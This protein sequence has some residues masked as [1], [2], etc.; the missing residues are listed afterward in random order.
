VVQ[1]SEARIPTRMGD[2]SLTEMTRGELRGDVEAATQLAARKAKV[3]PLDQD[4]LDHVLD[5]Y[6]SAARFTAVDIG[7]EVCLSSDGGGSRFVGTPVQDMIE[8]EQRLGHDCVELWHIEYS[9]KAIKTILAYEQQQMQHAQQQLIA[10]AQYGAMPNLGFYSQPD[11]PAPNWFE[12]LPQGRIDEA[13]AAVEEAVAYAQED[14]FFVCD[15]LLEVGADGVDFDT[16]GASGDADFLA[17]LTAT[18]RL[19]EKYPEAGIEIGMAGEFVLGVH[20][21]LEFDGERLAGMWPLAQ[22]RAVEKA[23][24]HIFGPC[25][26]INTTKSCAWNTTYALTLIKPAA[27]AATIPVHVNA[28]Q[29]VCGV[30]INGYPGCDATSRAAKSFV[31]VLRIDGL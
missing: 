11:G 5:I 20:G 9:Y 2:G 14:F 19:R 10:P 29:G 31:E 26:N 17:T 1:V 8:C 22:L 18:R 30:P 28:G 23:G 24:G 21:G 4:A 16:T 12:L 6:A 27:D 25:V 7:D 3:A 15:G 13:R